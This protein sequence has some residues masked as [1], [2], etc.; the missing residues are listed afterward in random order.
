VE[1]GVSKFVVT[2]KREV[3]NLKYGKQENSPFRCLQSHEKLLLILLH[4]VETP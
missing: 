3:W 2:V 1:D 4:R